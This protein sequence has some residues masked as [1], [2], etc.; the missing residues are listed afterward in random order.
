MKYQLKRRSTDGFLNGLFYEFDVPAYH[1]TDKADFPKGAVLIGGRLPKQNG[2]WLSDYRCLRILED[3]PIQVQTASHCI[4]CE[5]DGAYTHTEKVINRVAVETFQ[6]QTDGDFF[7]QDTY[8]SNHFVST[9]LAERLRKSNLSGVEFGKVAHHQSED[10]KLHEATSLEVLNVVGKR[11]WASSMILSEGVANACPHCGDAPIICPE[12]GM[13]RTPCKK[14]KKLIAIMAGHEEGADDRRLKFEP[15][16]ETL[17]IVAGRRWD[18]SDFMTG[19]L[20]TKRALDF[21]LSIHAAPFWYRPA[22]VDVTGVS[23]EK[24][25]QIRAAADPVIPKRS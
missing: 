15:A 11:C 25:K 8:A 6:G 4:R 1:Q 20:I 12:C 2:N 10:R 7:P 18:G 19:G 17:G 22:L 13:L 3:A 9:R 23:D 14:C 24:L 21:L 16:S 5:A